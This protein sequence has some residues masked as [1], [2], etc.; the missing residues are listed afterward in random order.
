M[1]EIFA[2]TA[3]WANFF[4]RSEPFHR[5]AVQLM[6]QWHNSQVRIITTNYVLTELVALF[7]SPLH[8][9]RNE[10]V[11]AIET[12]KT[13][14]WVEIIHI[15]VSLDEEAWQHLK[16]R[17]DKRW[18]LVDCASIIVMQHRNITSA[19]TTDHHFEQ[20]GFTNLLK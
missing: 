18:S 8:I 17:Q 13:A 3:G 4:V 15:D 20:A 9:P 11:R 2:D 12:I 19:F 16:Q 7:T 10:Q 6:Q 1:P 5:Q 14:S